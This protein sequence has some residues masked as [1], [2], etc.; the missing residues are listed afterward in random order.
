MASLRTQNGDTSHKL[1]GQ[2]CRFS[3][4]VWVCPEM[5]MAHSTGHKMIVNMMTIHWDSR[6]QYHVFRTDVVNAILNQTQF[7]HFEG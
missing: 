6:V 7:Y 3:T 1:P 2:L 5:G 4:S